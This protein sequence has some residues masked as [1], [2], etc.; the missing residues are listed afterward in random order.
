MFSNLQGKE[1]EP[2]NMTEDPAMS[3]RLSYPQSP[4]NL[5]KHL[6]AARQLQK[7]STVS[8]SE[9]D[10]PKSLSSTTQGGPGPTK[11]QV[12]GYAKFL[13]MDMKNDRDLFYLAREGL[14]APLPKEWKVITGERDIM[15]YLNTVTS[16]Q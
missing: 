8:S 2:L 6:P 15:L 10:N 11:Q 9:I 14:M 16:M 7:Q 3:Q 5:N 12:K 1:T 4:V 13:G